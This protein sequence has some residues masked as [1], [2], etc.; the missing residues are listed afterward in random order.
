MKL[1]EGRKSEV[2]GAEKGGASNQDQQRSALRADRDNGHF[3][4]ERN[5]NDV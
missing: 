3:D 5:L 1:K 4:I 2:K